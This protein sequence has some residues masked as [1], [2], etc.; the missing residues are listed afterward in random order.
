MILSA[1]PSG[2]RDDPGTR[3]SIKQ[4]HLPKAD[5]FGGGGGGGGEVEIPVTWSVLPCRSLKGLS[6]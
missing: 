5:A 1:N 6:A 4:H 2:A 3:L